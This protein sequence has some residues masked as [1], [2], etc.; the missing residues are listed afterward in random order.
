M[1]ELTTITEK[2]NELA[3]SAIAEIEQIARQTRD[4]MP[5][6]GGEKAFL[7]RGFALRTEA[8][9]QCLAEIIEGADQD[10]DRDLEY[11]V[12]GPSTA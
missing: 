9:V 6:L 5:E 10:N 1:A 2:R 7:L 8:L 11:T 3:L 12:Y 4:L